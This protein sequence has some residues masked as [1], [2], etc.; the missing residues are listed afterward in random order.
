MNNET[1]AHIGRWIITLGTLAT[2]TLAL[3]LGPWGLGWLIL[4]A[5]PNKPMVVQLVVPW[6]SGFCLFILTGATVWGTRMAV[7]PMVLDFHRWL[8]RD[9]R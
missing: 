1:A 7:C 6:I 9:R 4:P 5:R 2:A 3:L 8:W